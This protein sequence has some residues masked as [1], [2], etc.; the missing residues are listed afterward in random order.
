VTTSSSAYWWSKNIGDREI[1]ID[2]ITDSAYAYYWARDIGDKQIMRD[3][4]TDP[5]IEKFNQ[6]PS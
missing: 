4:I 6:L 5:Y 3:R 1:M 2:R